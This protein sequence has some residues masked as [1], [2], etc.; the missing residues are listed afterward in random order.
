MS[1]LGVLATLLLPVSKAA[2]LSPGESAP[3]PF[4]AACDVVVEGSRATAYCRNPYPDTDR[5]Q[6]HVECERWWDLD[7]DSHAVDVAPTAHA[8]L[9]ERCWKEIRTAWV[10]HVRVS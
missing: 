9:T 4:G 1:A 6:L 3:R 8:T 2:S 10:S 5:V 7:A